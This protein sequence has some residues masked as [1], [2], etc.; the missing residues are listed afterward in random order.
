MRLPRIY[1]I[2]STIGMA[3]SSSGMSLGN[4]GLLSTLSEKGILIHLQV[5][6]VAAAWANARGQGPGIL[7]GIGVLLV[8]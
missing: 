6:Q 5:R 3:L 8:R 2:G 4:R 1:G 7:A